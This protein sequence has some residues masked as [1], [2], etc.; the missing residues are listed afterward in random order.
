VGGDVNH[1]STFGSASAAYAALLDDLIHH[2][3]ATNSEWAANFKPGVRTHPIPYFGDLASAEVLTVGV[4]PSATEFEGRGWPVEIGGAALRDRLSS[5]FKGQ[6]HSWY[7]PWEDALARIG[8]SYRRNAAH[9]DVSPRATLSAADVPD[10][11][12]FEA[13]LAAD[14]PWMVRFIRLAPRVRLVLLCGTATKRYYLNDF[15]KRHL[16]ADVARL[17]GSVRPE[18]GSGKVWRHELVVGERRL[19]VWSCST[20]PSDR[21]Q[22]GL[23]AKRI[24]A[25]AAWLTSI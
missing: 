7:G 1:D 22:P 19:P 16:P 23:L 8:A 14:L 5:Y 21:R 12:R 9:V 18:P 11:K 20:S 13:M 2:V 25:D 24:E 3:S 15:V 6:P 10:R 4:N 17:E